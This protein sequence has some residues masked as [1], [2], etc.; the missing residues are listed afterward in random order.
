MQVAVIGGGI[1]GACTAYF[2]AAA[3]HQVVVLERYGNVAQESSFGHG[4]LVSPGL[5]APL[6]SP[7]APRRLMAYLSR[8]ESPVI[9]KPGMRPALWRWLRRWYDECQ[10]E[11]FSRNK[12]HMQ[13][14]V[15][16]SQDLLDRL[17]EHY[18]LEY[19]HGRG[20][21]QL[22]RSAQDWQAA[23]ILL[24][25]LADGGVVHRE[26]D[27]DAA[28]CIEPALSAATP[29]AGALHFPN[30]ESG[31][32][33]LFA[34]Q[35]RH[36][37]EDLGVQFLFNTEVSSL[38]SLA[39]GVRLRIGERAFQADA[40]VLAAG[41]DSLRLLAPL[42]PGLPLLAVNGFSATVAIRDFDAAPLAVVHDEAYQVS[43]TRM[44]R[45][46]RLAGTFELGKDDL[47]LTP[48]AIRTLVKC[49]DDWFPDAANYNTA[50]LWCGASRSLPACAPLL[51]PAAPDV[52][53][54]VA[55]GN[56]GWAMGSGAGK[57]DLLRKPYRHR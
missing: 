52:L 56:Q 48:S 39:E 21:L 19:E 28:R 57:M 53:L 45:R 55:D 14:L 11:R 36:I 12:Q 29:L 47:A 10:L 41:A 20:V 44:G 9:I 49:G 38:E 35:M 15:L 4:G 40:A 34:R 23:H 43:V 17:R 42:C 8:P 54:N 51:G 24:Q 50:S 5:A 37:C 13:R 7:G 30:D 33:A 32:G 3:G 46:V 1:V 6:A 2:L 22:F 31:N 25:V 27:A 16:Y 18:S 26:V